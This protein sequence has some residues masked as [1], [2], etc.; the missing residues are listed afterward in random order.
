MN[1]RIK[2]IDEQ[3]AKLQAERKRIEERENLP[4]LK[5]KVLNFIEHSYSGKQLME[6]HKLSDYGVW[7]IYGEDPNCDM[8][9]YHH[10]PLIA[11]V[12]GTLEKAIEYAVQS[13]AFYTWGGGGDIR[14]AKREEPIKL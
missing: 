12:E 1:S 2:Q 9:G 4:P 13:T 3:I 14:P 10:Q 6:K 5:Q 11:T 7:K 8:G